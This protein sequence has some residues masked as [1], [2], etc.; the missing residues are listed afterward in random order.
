MQVVSRAVPLPWEEL[1]WRGLDT[2]ERRWEELRRA[3][4][5]RGLDLSAAPVL[6]LTLVRL[7][8]DV[9]RCLWTYHHIL[10]DGWSLPVIFREV[11]T[12]YAGGRLE[13][14][15]P[16][17]DYIAWLKRRDAS[18]DEA[19]WREVLGDFTAATPL[20]GD[21]GP[22]A[23]G[24]SGT[25]ER[26]VELTAE[27][28]AALVAFARGRQLTLSNVVQGAWAL[29]LSRLTGEDDVVFGAVFSGRS[30]AL[31]GI[32]SMVG[33]FINTLPVRV[34]VR[35][36]LPAGVWLQQLQEERARQLQHE[37]TP[38]VDAQGWSGVPRGLP[39]FES[40]V[41]FENYPVDPP[42]EGDAAALRVELLPGDAGVP[43]P[44]TLVVVEGARLA[45][46]LGWDRARFDETAA[47]GLLDRLRRLLGSLAAAPDRPLAEISLLGEDER[48]R[49]LDGWSRGETAD[50]PDATLHELFAAR[51]AANPEA[52]ALEGEDGEAWTYGELDARAGRLAH[53]LRGLGAGVESRVGICLERTPEAF[54]ALLGALKA[55]AAYVPLDP[56][57]PDERLRWIVAAVDAA[58]LVTRR[59]LL[60]RIDPEA[61]RPALLLDEPE[62]EANGADPDVEVLPAN[63]AYVLFTS[64]S[65]GVPKG[66]TVPHRA[67]I[68]TIEHSR[69]LF[70]E[71]PGMRM[72]QVS[73]LT[74]DGSVL[75]VFLP[76]LTGGSLHPF[77]REAALSGETLAAEL[78]RR[79][80]THTFLVPAVLALL[81]PAELPDLRAFI[82]GGDRCPA[83]AAERWG[84][85]RGF[86]NIYG[87]TETV[88][89]TTVF[90]GRRP[91]LQVLPIGRPIANDEAF[92]LDR[93]GRPVPAGALGELYLGGA[94]MAR[95]YAG[96]PDLTAERFV[97]HPFAVAPGERLYRTGDLARWLPG[98]DLEFLG[99]TDHQVKI[100]GVR[101]ELG[102]VE[103][104]L[105]RHPAVRHA[106][107]VLRREGPEPRLV[108]YVELGPE[109]GDGFSP[110][111]DLRSFLAGIL[112]AAALPSTFVA[113]EAMPLTRTGK[114]DRRALP[115][116]EDEARGAD[117]VAPRDEAEQGLAAIWRELLG[118]PRVGAHDNFFE[119]G[120][121]SL[122]ITRVRSRVQ[123]AFGVDLP[124]ADL[125]AEP[126]LAEMA[127]AIR[128]ANPESAAAGLRLT[129][130]PRQRHS[131]RRGDLESGR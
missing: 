74:F 32:G 95:G 53:R 46:R 99:R 90:G 55:G 11:F 49:V 56:G 31:P 100:R 60:E 58:V 130:I 52:L 5:A 79:R 21:R 121:H 50:I 26:Q 35:E 7:A 126:T 64:G 120:G 73:G 14:A 62:G 65:T 129:A 43:Y 44:L 123:A 1:D 25:E 89:Y 98:G 86:F 85:G 105:E 118:V 81:P 128:R 27:E 61:S 57:L 34:R 106:A 107:A 40:L 131:M 116:L 8:D 83:E 66:V 23:A 19:Y 88:V 30:A 93:A 2:F 36:E 82:L 24:G 108:A 97:P 59:E 76:L 102:E 117:F 87:P 69:R 71:G 41:A 77:P 3:D 80:I 22:G 119:L 127:A 28:T 94:G 48:R 113:L 67:V 63:A 103:A 4:R 122:L 84:A 124:L 70:G 29:L 78:G 125:F 96:R 47:L 112:P 115:V 109:A 45:L 18:A 75:E 110:A 9:H 101:V 12:L 17:G 13:P 39:L 20:P 111:R 6:R 54:A 104:A 91:D 92:L 37:T 16:Y 38:L 68:N 15:R 42:S 10:I 51:A 33:P 72:A 114:I